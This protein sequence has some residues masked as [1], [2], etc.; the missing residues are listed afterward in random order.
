MSENTTRAKR[1]SSHAVQSVS[2]SGHYE[3]A[4]TQA[5]AQIQRTQV[6]ITSG[7]NLGFRNKG[8]RDDLIA[9]PYQ[10]RSCN[11]LENTFRFEQT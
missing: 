1:A 2:I 6:T 4:Q 10:I 11:T 8:G 9:S 5:E 3:I 7:S